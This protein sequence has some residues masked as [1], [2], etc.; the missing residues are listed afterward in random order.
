[1][2]S[3]FE[4]GMGAMTPADA[5]WTLKISLNA[6]KLPCRTSQTVTNI[7]HFKVQW[8]VK[9]NLGLLK[10]HLP[11]NTH[12]YW[13]YN[14]KSISAGY[15]T[16]TRGNIER[17]NFPTFRTYED[18]DALLDPA[19]CGI[20]PCW[21]VLCHQHNFNRHPAWLIVHESYWSCREYLVQMVVLS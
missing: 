18:T 12:C 10:P 21:S 11:S 9:N 14:P 13:I 8:N 2:S 16:I 5:A 7:I 19:L 6:I 1:M 20:V 4:S 15:Q 3:D 17:E